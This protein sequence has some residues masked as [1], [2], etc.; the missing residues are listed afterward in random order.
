MDSSNGAPV[1]TNVLQLLFFF[2]LQQNILQRE[3][4]EWKVYFGSWLQDTVHHRED[5]MAAGV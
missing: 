1:G 3:L 5:V 2:L 4:E